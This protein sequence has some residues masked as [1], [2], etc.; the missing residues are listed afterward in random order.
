MIAE[1]NG[2]KLFYEKSGEGRPLVMVHGNGEDHTIFDE[3]VRELKGEYTCYCLDS[4]CHGKST[5][6]AELHYRDMATD[7]IRG[8]GIIADSY[9]QVGDVILYKG[10]EAEVLTIGIRTTR[11]RILANDN[12]LSIANRNIS[13]VEVL[14]WKYVES[15][16]MPYDLS[17]Y[18]SEKVVRDIVNRISKNEFVENCK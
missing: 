3:A 16:P 4:R 9:C 7:V 8:I 11:V 15:F 12:I 1:V 5:D 6:T 10:M 18:Q 13:E 14:S 2:V 17:I